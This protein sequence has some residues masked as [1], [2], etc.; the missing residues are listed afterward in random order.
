M[1]KRLLSA[2]LALAMVLTLLPATA[3]A[4]IIPATGIQEPDEGEG[5][6]TVYYAA[7]NNAQYGVDAGDWYWSKKV[8]SDTQYYKVDS[9]VVASTGSSGRW[10]SGI[11]QMLRTG[12]AD[13]YVSTTITLL[14]S[15]TIPNLTQNL[16]VDVN[17]NKLTISAI[18]PK[19][20]SL[21]VT[22]SRWN[23]L[24]ATS[25]GE[26]KIADMDA[27]RQKSGINLTL[28]DVTLNS[29]NIVKRANTVTLTRVTSTGDITLNGTTPPASTG[30]DTYLTQKLTAT[31]CDLSGAIKVTGDNSTVSLTDTIGE[32]S[33]TMASN[34]GS[35]T[36]NGTSKVGAVEVGS[37][38]SSS[39]AKS[40]KVPSVTV[41]GGTVESI[42]RTTTDTSS[43]AGVIVVG[44]RGAAVHSVN[45][46]NGIT[47]HN[48][49]VT[50]NETTIGGDTAIQTGKLT[51]NGPAN[52][53]E[54]VLGGAAPNKIE[55]TVTGTR[56]RIGD[57]TIT[58]DNEGNKVSIPDDR[59]NQFGELDLG[60]YRGKGIL[61][62]SFLTIPADE[63]AMNWFSDD[64]QFVGS[65]S[66]ANPKRYY[67]YDKREL[68]DA[69]A[70]LGA[71]GRGLDDL[72]VF[73]PE[74]GQTDANKSSITFMNGD[75]VVAGVWYWFD[76]SI[77]LPDM[78]N[79][80]PVVTWVDMTNGASAE[81]YP[82][83]K[84]TP[85]TVGASTVLN[86]QGDVGAVT[87]L[88][89]ATVSGGNNPNVKV[90]VAN[91]QISLSGAVS[92]SYGGGTATILLT[93]VTDLVSGDTTAPGGPSADYVT[94]DVPVS[95]D[96]VAKTGS[97][98][99]AGLSFP[100]GV[101]V[102]DQTITVGG[103]VYTLNV[104]GLGLPAP[105][106]EIDQA[107]N[108]V[109]VNFSGSG[110][111]DGLKQQ[112][113]EFFENGF[114]WQHSPALRQAINEALK[115]ISSESTVKNFRTAAQRA[116]WNLWNTSGGND[117]SNLDSTQYT[118]VRLVPYLNVTVSK[119]LSSGT[120]NFTAVPYYRVEVRGGESGPCPFPENDPKYPNRA[121]IA[122]AG[123]TLGDLGTT[124]YGLDTAD[125]GAKLTL[126]GLPATFT[127]ANLHQDSTYVYDDASNGN[128]VSYVLT[129]GGKTGLGT[130]EL[131]SNPWTVE[132][133]HEVRPVAT[134]SYYTSLQ[135]AV[136]DTVARPK[137][138]E[139]EVKILAGYKGSE[140]VTLTGEA[141]K[142]KIDSVGN[143][144]VTAGASGTIVETVQTG[145]KYEV[146]LLN[147]TAATGTV[148]I[149]VQNVNYGTAVASASYAKTGSVVTV[150]TTPT[151][152]YRTLGVSV[153][154]D[155]G[156]SVSVTNK[157]NN[158]YTFTVPTDAKSITVT[159]SFGSG[160]A[161]N[162]T[163][164]TTSNGLA[165]PSATQ[166]YA[167]Q[168]VTITTRPNT[169]YRATGVTVSTNS[170]TVTATR[171][172]ENTYTFTVPANATYVTV[173]PTFAA[174]TGLPFAD[175][176]ANDFY[177]DAV[178]FVYNNGLMNGITA[179]TF[180]GSRTITRGQIVT[181]LYR[182]SGSPTAS[183][184]SSFQDV[185]A[186]EYY[187]PAITWAASNA[188]VNGRN[189]TTFA[190]NDAITR[191]ELAAIL[192]RY[193]SFRGLTNNKL[194]SLSGYTDQGQVDDYASIPMQWCVGN[195]IINGTSNTTLTPRGTAQRYQAAIMLM[196][197]CQSFLG[198]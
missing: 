42:K 120:L 148:P 6:T 118:L 111:T 45:V 156:K 106:I 64:L 88:R 18:D 163:V 50:I 62:G 134:K 37:R 26:V 3:F 119:Y 142:I 86:L 40:V 67:Y 115:T 147:S 190:P 108:L 73:S 173:T 69:I 133:T 39:P 130:L 28:S 145:H 177:L 10:Y 124:L 180:G 87:K 83:N 41:N 102:K 94:F 57:I 146:Q 74:D 175:V 191:Q 195:G 98:G 159:P 168:Q 11:D 27:S 129:H 9:G 178:K 65:N 21:K 2:F 59:D 154:T 55:L 128:K 17:G 140:V 187:A 137:G 157:G 52:M 76:T 49:D 47:T 123:R 189:S 139:N 158:V 170:G 78:I 110:W 197:Y 166:V 138:N 161:A 141:R 164:T 60:T 29:I 196:R 15:D 100:K 103:N 144:N 179:T 198:M 63:A 96:P 14:E 84:L 79:G 70:D 31:S 183:S 20:T 33:I 114:E 48:G 54:L 121:Y 36:I 135:A 99:S 68:S 85:I 22:D 122:Q 58:G 169:G 185:P 112:V 172:A 66:V 160:T 93:L 151:G 4:A 23:A 152:S 90:S 51:I 71:S 82:V 101:V 171:T 174:D 32:A 97:F 16:T 127:G 61:G 19:V 186:G 75:K 176:P 182:L 149:T 95:Y 13:E 167:G 35:V 192:Y 126:T 92:T 132:L 136:D 5:K 43:Q 38:D 184:Y 109:Q 72:A 80:T 162:L 44:Q 194:T 53:G 131:N 188:I 117:Q 81:T 193:T 150:T 34:G 107:S 181:I 30:S 165:V 89:N 12:K 113:T 1:K 8:G 91:N 116:A 77:Y 25:G 105:G 24:V 155:T 7:K 125:V 104:S 46:T 153:T 143:T 56:N